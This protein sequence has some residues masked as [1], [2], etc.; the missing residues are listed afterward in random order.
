V[1][2]LFLIDGARP[3]PVRLA[4][5]ALSDNKAQVRVAAAMA[6]G[7]LHAKSR[8]SEAGEGRWSDKETVSHARRCSLSTHHEG[9][10]WAYEVYYEIPHRRTQE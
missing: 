6:L 1:R 9:T 2:A 3:E 8:D 7:E 10:R 4:S 5:G